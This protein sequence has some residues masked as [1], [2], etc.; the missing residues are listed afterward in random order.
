M[1]GDIDDPFPAPPRPPRPGPPTFIGGLDLGQASDYTALAI[2]EKTEHVEGGERVASYAVRH[3]H[4][5]QLKTPYPQI[6]AEVVEKFS[7]PPLA[8]SALAVDQTGVG[9]PVVD[10]FR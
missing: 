2:V 5:W 10:L 4:R 1:K 9:R 6:V 7:R 3:L 8:D